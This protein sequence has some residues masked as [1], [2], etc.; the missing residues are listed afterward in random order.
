MF[1][2]TKLWQSLAALTANLNALAETVGTIN[3][4]LRQH[5]GLDGHNPLDMPALPPPVAQ[6]TLGHAEEGQ[7]SAKSRRR[8][9]A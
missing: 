6:D 8:K 5:I 7:G 3:V 1:G 4:G 2:L 9:A